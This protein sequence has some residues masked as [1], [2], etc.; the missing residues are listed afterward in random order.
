MRCTCWTAS[1]N[2]ISRI[3]KS[4][5]AP[6]APR[7]VCCSP[8]ERC[9]SN[10]RMTRRSMTLSI[11]FSLAPGC[12]AMIISGSLWSLLVHFKIKFRFAGCFRSGGAV[13]LL[14]LQLAHD[15]DNAFEDM[16]NLAIRQRALIGLLHA[17]EHMLLALGFVNGKIGVVLQLADLPR[18]RSSLID[19][20][21]QFEIQ[22]IDFLTPIFYGHFAKL[23]ACAASLPARSPRINVATSS[24]DSVPCF[25]MIETIALP[26][27]A[28]SANSPTA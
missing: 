7:T 26:I 21:Y 3:S 10:P 13:N 18:C 20:L 11:C 14:L 6:T 23:S 9:T 5:F 15:V 24:A 12:M 16:L 19:Q 1:S 2:S 22:L 28:A 17:L 4:I 25:S 27:A 8:V